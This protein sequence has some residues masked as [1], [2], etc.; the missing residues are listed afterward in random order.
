MGIRVTR[1]YNDGRKE[2]TDYV[3]FGFLAQSSR[4]N[5]QVSK[6]SFHFDH[7]FRTHEWGGDADGMFKT[8]LTELFATAP[9]FKNFSFHSRKGV[10]TASNVSTM[11]C[12]E[13]MTG[14]F[15]ARNLA[16]RPRTIQTYRWLREQGYRPLIALAVSHLYER[17]PEIGTFD[18]PEQRW[19]RSSQSEGTIFQQATFGREAFLRF[20]RQDYSKREFKPW[21]QEP[22]TVQK[23]YLRDSLIQDLLGNWDSPLTELGLQTKTASKKTSHRRYMA[24]ALSIM[25]GK[26]TPLHPLGTSHQTSDEGMK[27]F[28]NSFLPQQFKV[29]VDPSYTPPV[30]TV[31]ADVNDRVVLS[32]SGLARGYS[33]E[34]N[35]TSADVE[36]VVTF[37]H[38]NSRGSLR[39]AWDNGMQNVYD[40]NDIVV[41]SAQ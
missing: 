37:R 16:K 38:T 9:M 20:I 3:C 24:S 15:I 23:R 11:P 13:L 7:G 18:D 5:E 26:E 31:P 21:V 29:E 27:F 4:N 35:P 28:L 39:V 32:A 14:L 10:V 40:N 25:K 1:E 12:D 33:P 8:E 19:Y 36:G 34:T 17:K 6:I 30:V 2:R 22:F 41:I